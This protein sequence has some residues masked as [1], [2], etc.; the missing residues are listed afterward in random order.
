LEK[1]LSADIAQHPKDDA[2]SLVGR[3]R[4]PRVR[5]LLFQVEPYDVDFEESLFLEHVDAVQPEFPAGHADHFRHAD[6]RH[7]ASV[8]RHYAQRHRAAEGSHRYETLH[9]HLAKCSAQS[10]DRT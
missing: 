8:N 3:N 4:Y 6:A 10:E 9:S 1:H 5:R 7:L 2:L